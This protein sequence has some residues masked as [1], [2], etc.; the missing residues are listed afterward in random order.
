[1]GRSRNPAAPA[2]M[3]VHATRRNTANDRKAGAG[4]VMPGQRQALKRGGAG[5]ANW[6]RPGEEMYEYEE[7]EYTKLSAEE[8]VVIAAGL[9]WSE[10]DELSDED[11]ANMA[12]VEAAMQQDWLLQQC[13]ESEQIQDEGEDF[14][15]SLDPKS[16]VE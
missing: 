9:E 4:S 1:M 10:V 16:W 14:F 12:E 7:E 3:P 13:A 8:A 15:N 11:Q 2:T 5:A 6:G